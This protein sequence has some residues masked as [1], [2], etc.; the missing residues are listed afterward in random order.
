MPVRTRSLTALDAA[1]ARRKPRPATP[2]PTYS[3]AEL[4]ERRRK[5]LPVT[6]DG[7]FDLTEEIR[8]IVGPLADRIATDPHPLTFAVQVDDVVV[9]VAGSVRTLAVL[10]AEREARRRCQNVPIGNRGQAVRALVALAD[11]PADPEITD[12]DI[13]SGRW[14]AILTEHAATYSADLA[15]YLA[16][17]IPPGQTRGLLS[18]SE[19]TEDALR[20]IDTAAT[21]LARR[22]SYVENLREQTNDTGTSSTEAEAAR[23]TL[24]DL[25]ITP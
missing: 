1:R 4:R 18:V 11:K 12:D 3:Q 13:R 8:A 10:L 19:H 5:H 6:Y 24:A 21:N 9:A 7:R 15:D 16:H 22:L 25:G 17:A 23:Q 14:A 2:P 20:E